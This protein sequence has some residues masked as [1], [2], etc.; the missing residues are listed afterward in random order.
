MGRYRGC[1]CTTTSLEPCNYCQSEGCEECGEQD[2]VCGDEEEPD[3]DERGHI[4][5][6]EARYENWLESLKD[7]H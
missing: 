7:R 3:F 1:T 6:E 2:C 5:Q 4:V